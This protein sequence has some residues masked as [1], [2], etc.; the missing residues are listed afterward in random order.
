MTEAILSR[1]P[2]FASLTA[3]EV[4]RLLNVLPEIKVPVGVVFVR[5]GDRGEDLYIL[6]E[7]EIEVVKAL[8]TEEES[9][10]AIRGVGHVVGEMSLINPDGLRGASLRSRTPARLLR[11]TRA[12]FDDL[13][14]RH[15]E[16][17]FELAL[18]LA[19]K[20]R[21]TDAARIQDLQVKNQ[22]LST[23]Y[24][25]LRAAQEQ[26]VEKQVLDRELA[27]AREIQM[28]ML[29]RTMPAFEGFDF[30]AQIVPARAVG[31]DFFDF[32]SLDSKTLG[33]V[34]A[35]VSGKGMPA[36]LFMALTR[37]LLRSAAARD[38]T[39]REVLNTVNRQ[40][41]ETNDAGL[42][43]TALYGVLHLGT[44]Q[45]VYARAGH[46][47]PL[48]VDGSRIEPGG[49]QGLPLGLFADPD[50][51]EQ[52]FAMARGCSLL[53]YTDGV[54]DAVDSAGLVL[55]PERLRRA[56]GASSGGPAQEICDGVLRAVR[57]H[58]GTAAQADD[59]T[60]LAIRSN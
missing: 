39:P 2:L 13:L 15:P 8:G 5:E 14:H 12:D 52:V 30:G 43:V 3:A 29:P 53:L 9:L 33:I 54:T 47:L 21:E 10:L 7:G 58:Q 55:G 42:F 34:V 59:I 40:L 36:A 32:I 46:E 22:Q 28:G 31:G 24:L 27:L 4:R 51:N 37:S 49:G 48:M 57:E 45:F 60:L 11:M 19:A 1:M 25:E 44:R 23:A 50:L 41:L 38:S 18:T 17:A 16:L 20:V 6:L 26:I 35:D 56:L